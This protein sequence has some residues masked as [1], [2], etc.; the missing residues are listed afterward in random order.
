MD[1]LSCQYIKKDDSICE[2]GCWRASECARHYKTRP[3]TI[4]SICNELTYSDIRICNTHGGF[5]DRAWHKSKKNKTE[6]AGVYKVNTSPSDIVK[7]LI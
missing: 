4:C 3:K 1:R 7:I 5:Y 2:K 6:S